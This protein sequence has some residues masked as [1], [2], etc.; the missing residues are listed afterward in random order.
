MHVLKFTSLIVCVSSIFLTKGV[1][2]QEPTRAK[3]KGKGVLEKQLTGLASKDS[4]IMC[5]LVGLG[6]DFVPEI[7]GAR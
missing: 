7:R 3:Q 2:A 6:P 5:R 4:D 1:V